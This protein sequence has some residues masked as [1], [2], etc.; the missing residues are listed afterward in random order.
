MLPHGNGLAWGA[1]SSVCGQQSKKLMSRRFSGSS[2][3]CQEPSIL[4][5][6]RARGSFYMPPPRRVSNFTTN[7]CWFLCAVHTKWSQPILRV[8]QLGVFTT[9]YT[10]KQKRPPHFRLIRVYLPCAPSYIAQHMHERHRH[11]HAKLE[12]KYTRLYWIKSYDW[13]C[14]TRFVRR[15]RSFRQ[16]VSGQTCSHATC[17]FL[18][19]WRIFSP[20]ST[21]DKTAT[22]LISE[23]YPHIRIVNFLSLQEHVD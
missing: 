23:S 20:Y 7:R 10:H 11:T 6:A 5:T 21:I 18:D 3:L 14:Y 1:V 4:R 13:S 19:I 22:I 2:K 15:S 17:I 9:T 16:W 12:L 8:S